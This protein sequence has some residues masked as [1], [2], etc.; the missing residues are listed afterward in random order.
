MAG[1][2]IPINNFDDV[3]KEL[4]RVWINI[5]GPQEKHAVAIRSLHAKVTALGKLLEQLAPTFNGEQRRII[6]SYPRLCKEAA[7][8]FAGEQQKAHPSS[9]QTTRR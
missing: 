1:M 4:D 2:K 8:V 3:S 6:D 5:G 9:A 7:E